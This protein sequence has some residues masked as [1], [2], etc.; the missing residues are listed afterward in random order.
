[1]APAFLTVLKWIFRF[2]A[3]FILLPTGYYKL[4]ADPHAV[5]LFT[6]LGA[7]PAG[8]IAVGLLELLAGLL[9]L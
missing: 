7:E 8:R 3:A 5:H 2:L 1:M 9:M 4:M 6:L